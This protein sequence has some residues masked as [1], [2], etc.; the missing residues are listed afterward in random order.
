M[1]PPALKYIV[2]SI[3]KMSD[4]FWVELDSLIE[5]KN[6]PKKK[7]ILK[8]GEVCRNLVFI[9]SG[10]ARAYYHEDGNQV[11]S[12]FMKENDMIISVKSFFKQEPSMENMEALEDSQMVFLSYEALNYL[13]GK[14]PE[15]NI[16]GRILTEH[17]YVLSE[18]RLFSLR[19]HTVEERYQILLKLHPEILKRAPLK[20]VASY[21]SMTPET[22]SRLRALR[23]S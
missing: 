13:Y 5:I 6:I 10:M 19:L 1:T 18:E 17:Y 20:Y 2:D 4:S 11:T 14:Y 21:L 22:L 15:Y 7:F 23:I 8:E 3:W 16:V 9:I 12:W